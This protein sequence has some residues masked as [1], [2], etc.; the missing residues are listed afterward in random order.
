MPA[1]HSGIPSARGRG[2]SRGNPL[3]LVVFGRNKDVRVCSKGVGHP[4]AD[5]RD[6]C[7]APYLEQ[8]E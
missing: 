4:L 5:P 1:W 3:L 7:F 8:I 6:E 2:L